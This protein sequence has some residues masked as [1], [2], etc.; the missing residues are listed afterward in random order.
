MQ[1]KLLWI[2]ISMVVDKLCI[3]SISISRH[4][5][6]YCNHSHIPFAVTRYGWNDGSLMGLRADQYLLTAM[7]GMALPVFFDWLMM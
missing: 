5:A 4:S 3:T 7:C 6:I 2:R 1:V